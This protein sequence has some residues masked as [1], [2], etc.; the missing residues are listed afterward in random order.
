MA[1]LPPGSF[2]S[3]VTASTRSPSSCSEFRQ[4]KSRSWFE[5]TILRTSPSAFA[6]A[7]S[8]SP[9]SSRSGHAPA[10]LSYVV[11]PKS[12]VSALL[13]VAVT[14]APISSLK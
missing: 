1:M 10:K 14:A 3:A 11:R 13:K 2:F 12:I 8:S 9:A 7:A 4:V 6:K 5:T